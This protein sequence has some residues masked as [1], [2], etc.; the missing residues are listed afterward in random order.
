MATGGSKMVVFDKD[1]ISF[2]EIEQEINLVT[3]I[4]NEI[5]AQNVLTELKKRRNHLDTI[6]VEFG[7]ITTALTDIKHRLCESNL[8][9]ASK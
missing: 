9:E 5:E 4:D 1:K 3:R 7:E 8:M 2:S 6:T